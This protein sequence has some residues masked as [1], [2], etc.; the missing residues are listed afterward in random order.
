VKEPLG[1]DWEV[2]D[3]NY[4]WTKLDAFSLGFDVPVDKDGTAVLKYRVRV[5]W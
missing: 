4:K 5:R 3:S 2:Q 1:G